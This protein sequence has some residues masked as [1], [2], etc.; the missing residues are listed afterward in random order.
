MLKQTAFTEKPLNALEYY[1]IVVTHI[2]L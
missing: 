2:G 1:I